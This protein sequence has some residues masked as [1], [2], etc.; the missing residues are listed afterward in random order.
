[1]HQSIIAS[2][3][4]KIVWYWNGKNI[5]QYKIQLKYMGDFEVTITNTK[6]FEKNRK[7]SF[8]SLEQF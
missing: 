7:K 3:S 1:M 6:L 4:E 8:E 2:S 5:E